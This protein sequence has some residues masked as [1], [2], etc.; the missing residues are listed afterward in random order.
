MKHFGALR[1]VFLVLRDIVGQT[2]AMSDKQAKVNRAAAEIVRY[3]HAIEKGLCIRNIRAGFGIA[4][5]DAIFDLMDSYGIES[6]H[7]IYRQSVKMAMASIGSYLRYHD[8][9]QFCNQDI[10]RIRVRF[11]RYAEKM[12]EE[13]QPGGASEINSTGAGVHSPGVKA[14]FLN[15]HSIR[16]F[17]GGHVDPDQLNEALYLAGR[18]PSA[19][20]RQAVRTYIFEKDELQA[21][22]AFFRGIGG[23]ENEFDKALLI[24]SKQS[25]YRTIEIN[26]HIVSAGIYAGYLSLALEIMDIGAC[27]V[28]RPLLISREWRAI[29]ERYG[30]PNDE[31]LVCMMCIGNKKES[32]H[33]PVSHRYRLDTVNRYISPIQQSRLTRF[34]ETREEHIV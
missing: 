18:Y 25:A 19:C 17:G 34:C 26:Q 22:A 10:A 12:P 8:R 4:K 20:N 15:R 33:V 14:V 11:K 32:Y 16:D 24:T 28:Q 6:D 7:A 23:F 9:L 3:T 27:I 29:R 30:I 13:A 5:I 21:G 2:A 1:V 31:Q